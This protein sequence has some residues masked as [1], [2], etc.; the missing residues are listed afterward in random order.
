MIQTLL[1]IIMGILLILFYVENQSLKDK[2]FNLLKKD[3]DFRNNLENIIHSGNNEIE[4]AKMINKKYHIGIL[5]SKTLIT[6]FLTR[7]KH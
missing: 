6:E 4:S 3:K 7:E 5:K 1:I 2:Y